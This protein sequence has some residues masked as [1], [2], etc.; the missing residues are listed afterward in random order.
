VNGAEQGASQGLWAP[1]P[2]S[3]VS[4]RVSK[5]VANHLLRPDYR[6]SERRRLEAADG[7]PIHVAH[8]SGPPR[9]GAAVVLVHGFASSS[10]DPA[11]FR[12]AHLLAERYEVVVPDLRGHGRSGGHCTFGELEPLDV[13]AALAAVTPGRPTVTVGVSLGAAAVLLHASDHASAE[14]AGSLPFGRPAGRLAGV[15]AVSA[16]AWFEDPERPG[17]ANVAQSAS[18]R[19]RR[20]ALATLLGTRVRDPRTLAL[21]TSAGR[22][23]RL[24]GLPV[25]LVH[26]PYDRYF[27]PEHVLDILT[28]VG[29]TAEVCWAR[30]SGHGSELLDIWLARRIATMVERVVGVE[31]EPSVCRE[32]DANPSHHGG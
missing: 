28:R 9:A 32:P 29:P 12:F 27:G 2:P 5:W 21:P 10:R 19:W 14:E 17:A 25:L 23:E 6:R 15:V 7:T 24:A 4:A 8:L 1:P 22:A 11:I 20:L 13:A 26:D 3:G 18:V 31:E 16:P 30:G